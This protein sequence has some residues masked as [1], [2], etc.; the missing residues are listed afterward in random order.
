MS[1]LGPTSSSA[2][3][4]RA[5]LALGLALGG[6]LLGSVAGTA[7]AAPPD[8]A[9]VRELLSGYEDVP[10]AETW[11]ALGPETV[12]V[13][14]ALYDDAREAPYVRMRAVVVCAH[15]PSP[16]TR[17]F[18]R[19]VAGAPGQSDLFVR[20][21]LEALARGFGDAALGD[22]RPYLDHADPSVREGAARS[23]G[24]LRAPAAATALRARL[25][26]ETDA[27]VRDALGRALSR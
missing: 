13:L 16:A 15:Y 6:V 3:R 7:F 19:A 23:I 26:V 10:P 4:V 11:R 22:L 12:G 18:L 20:A 24:R 14:V 27:A 9:K 2:R 21:A 25:R 8:P 5:P 17:T 1:G